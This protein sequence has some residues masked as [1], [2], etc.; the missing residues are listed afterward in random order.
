MH[1]VV[2][3]VANQ[4]CMNSTDFDV[5]AHAFCLS[6]N[7][8]LAAYTANYVATDTN[9]KQAFTTELGA[10]RYHSMHLANVRNDITVL[11]S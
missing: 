8:G 10:R 1:E 5:I 9:R 3:V 2:V 7:A 6:I 4:A 11:P